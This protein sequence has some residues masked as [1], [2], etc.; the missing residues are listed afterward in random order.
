ME[1]TIKTKYTSSN[2]KINAID[3][4]RG[5]AIL[6]VILVHTAQQIDGAMFLRQVAYYGQMGVQLFFVVS[7]FT[8]CHTFESRNKE[9]NVLVKFY[10]RRFFRIAPGYYFGILLYIVLG[11]YLG[12]AWNRSSDYLDIILNIF[13]LNGIVPSANNSVVPGGWSIG[14]E[15]I[16]YF[17]FPFLYV[18]FL[19]MQKKIR[20]F[21]VIFPFIFLIISLVI[22]FLFFILT[23]N[24]NYYSNNGFI[25]FSIL[26]QLP[27]F[28]MGISLHYYFKNLNTK[29]SW[30]KNTY[31]MFF[32]IL[33]ILSALVLFKGVNLT[34]FY[35]S[36]FPVVSA[37][38]FVYLFLF[39]DKMKIDKK[40]I[41]SK[42]GVLSY[43]SY[44]VH[45]AY[46]F[47]FVK[48]VSEK[49]FNNSYADI[50]LLVLYLATVILT[51]YSAKIVYNI[52][53]KNGLKLGRKIINY[54]EKKNIGR[55]KIS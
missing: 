42:I 10:T 44:L 51:Y 26:N 52:I 24:P 21:Y 13:F 32:C 45:C 3:I 29:Y 48:P 40:T 23:K 30:S 39:I 17:I 31:F 1:S 53:E 22:Q 4:M 15:M 50:K 41:F 36:L 6:A 54:S 49:I 27:V 37:L 7:A 5:I 25:Y 43:S 2:V 33:T 55:Q 16:F 14:T 19:K 35:T 18:F 34:I 20:F 47:Y 46:T 12:D 8:L 28:C 9:K 38:S 11:F